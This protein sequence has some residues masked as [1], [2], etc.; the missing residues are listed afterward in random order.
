[1]VIGINSKIQ[2]RKGLTFY[3]KTNGITPLKKHVDVD[4]SLITQTF[5]EEVNSLLRG[6]DERQP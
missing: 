6:N 5:E 3:Y 2:A 4:H 1:L